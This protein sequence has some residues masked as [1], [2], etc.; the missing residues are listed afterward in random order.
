[1]GQ[2][3]TGSA[4]LDALETTDRVFREGSWIPAQLRGSGSNAA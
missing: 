4:L 3:L 1:M 2:L